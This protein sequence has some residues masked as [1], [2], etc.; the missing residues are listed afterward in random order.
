MK[1]GCNTVVFRRYS[2]DVALERIHRAGYRYVEVEGNAPYC[3]HVR[4]KEDDPAKFRDRILG[5]GFISITCLGS[6]REL[7]SEEKAEE[8]IR[9][10]LEFAAE[11][12]IPVVATGE[13]RLPDGMSIGEALDILRPKFERLVSVAER[14]KVYLAIEPHGSLSLSPGGLGKIISLAP[15]PWLTINY[16]T[17]NPR[18][19]AYV[20]ISGDAY[21][22]KSDTS[23]R[24]DELAVLEPVVDKVS[25]VH[26]KDVVGRNAVVLGQGEVRLRELV[27]MLNQAGY[28]GTLSYETE[29]AQDADESQLMARESLVYTR[30]LLESLNIMID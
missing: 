19:A 23:E 24:G 1:I 5:F 30:G 7:I 21:E 26:V 2:L 18:R 3:D 10:S 13:G 20:G 11:A 9:Y 15:S 16:D 8:D 25:H 22:W 28:N 27:M 17:A 12:G 4:T 29:G 6:H 14:C